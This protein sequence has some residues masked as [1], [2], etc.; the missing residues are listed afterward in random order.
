MNIILLLIEIL[1][2]VFALI[3]LYNKQKYEGIYL[4][5]L[6]FSIFIGIFS[7]KTTEIFGLEIN[8][9]FVTNSLLFIASNIL[10][11]KKGPEEIKKILSTIFVGSVI[12]FTISIISVLLTSSTI[13]EITNKSFDKLFYLNNRIY[14]S[15]IISLIIS[16]WLNAKLYHQIRQIKNKIVISNILSTIIIHFVECI[17]FCVLSYTFK[18][19]FINIIELIVI[20]Y[21]FKV[22]IG[23]IGT[24]IIYMINSYER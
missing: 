13:N 23:L 11:Q 18:I 21:I 4:W 20:R 10:V 14:F 17:L 19:P 15:S 3:Y 22:S 1:L 5:I 6:I 7:Q 9:G 8:L 12:I 2:S 16:L 24:N